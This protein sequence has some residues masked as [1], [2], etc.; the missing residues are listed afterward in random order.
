ML[1]VLEF[2]AQVVSIICSGLLCDSLKGYSGY[3]SGYRQSWIPYALVSKHKLIAFIIT[4]QYFTYNISKCHL[5]E[6]T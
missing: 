4:M 1:S 5:L 3:F 6:N 2:S